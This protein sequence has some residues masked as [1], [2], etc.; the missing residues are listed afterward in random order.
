METRMTGKELETCIQ[1]LL[2]WDA[3]ELQI[4]NY[5]KTG[6]QED[7]NEYADKTE[8]LLPYLMNDA[9]EY[10]IR[11]EGCVLQGSWQGEKDGVQ[12]VSFEEKEG[13]GEILILQ[14]GDSQFRIRYTKAWKVENCYQY[15]RIGHNW[16]KEKGQEELR[17]MVNLLCVLH[18]K[19]TYLGEECSTEGEGFLASLI[20][21]QP[22]CY[23]TPINSSIEEWYPETLEGIYAMEELV[24]EAGDI[25]YGKQLARYRLFQENFDE[26]LSGRRMQKQLFRLRALQS[27]LAMDLV[28]K[29]HR[30]ILDLLE[31]KL[32]RESLH[33]KKRSYGWD[34]EQKMQR[35]RRE[36]EEQYRKEGFKGDYP[37][38][39]REDPDSG[40]RIRVHFVEE[41]PFMELEWSDYRFQIHDIVE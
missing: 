4:K 14:S 17:R 12:A 38:M 3:L 35:L 5:E 11:L 32:E 40:E 34:Q 2:E 41:H 21:F 33:W 30:A 13:F 27:A 6:Q 9:V 39:Y 26:S 8:V 29:Q 25:E 15:H 31:E 18:D 24:A 23:W 19:C 28:Q 36:K 37:R 22:L 16:R 7:W 1:E 10:F 20:E